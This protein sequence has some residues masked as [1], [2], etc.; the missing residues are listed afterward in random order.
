[1]LE[2]YSPLYGVAGFMSF[3]AENSVVMVVFVVDRTVREILRSWYRAAFA[4]EHPYFGIARDRCSLLIL[5]QDF[6]MQ[7]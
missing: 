6:Y 7:A 3:V 5:L 1:M 4:P 2:R